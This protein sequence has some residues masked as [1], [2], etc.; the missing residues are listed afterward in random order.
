M[1]FFVHA[2]GSWGHKS[3]N[4]WCCRVSQGWINRPQLINLNALALFCMLSISFSIHPSPSQPT[5]QPLPPHT[6]CPRF[7]LL[8]LLILYVFHLHWI[9]WSILNVPAFNVREPKISEYYTSKKRNTATTATTTIIITIIMNTP[10]KRFGIQVLSCKSIAYFKT[11]WRLLSNDK[12]PTC[13]HKQYFCYCC[14]R[15]Y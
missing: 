8:R 12:R 9:S 5:N 13:W 14:F 7:A 6:S 3:C 1:F 11:N 4:W 10:R 15:N 2:L